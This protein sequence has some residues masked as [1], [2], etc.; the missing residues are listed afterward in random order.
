MPAIGAARSFA[1]MGSLEKSRNADPSML[2]KL[3][4][5]GAAFTDEQWS[6]IAAEEPWS[7][8]PEPR[9][10]LDLHDL[11]LFVKAF[12]HDERDRA[13]AV[14]GLERIAERA[15]ALAARRAGYMRVL[16]DS[17]IAGLPLQARFSIDLCRWMCE[18]E[19]GAAAIDSLEGEEDRLRE[20]L[21]ASALPAERDAMDDTRF[22]A[23]SR[24]NDACGG[25]DALRWLIRAIDGLAPDPLARHALWESCGINV[26]LCPGRSPMARTWCEGVAG[27]VHAWRHGTKASVDARAIISTPLTDNGSVEG[28][29]R[30]SALA[31]ARGVL[32]GY[33]RETDPLTFCQPSA[34]RYHDM[35]Q[36][37]GIALFTMPPHRRAVFDPYVGYMAFSNAVPVAYGGAWLFPGKS[38]VGINVFPAFRGGPSQ[39]LFAQILRCYAQRYGVGCFEAENYQLGHGNSDGIRSGAYWF[40]HR[41][42]FRTPDPK[43]AAVAEAEARSMRANP[44]HR[45]KPALLRKLA[46]V[47][48]HLD[49]SGE[50]APVFEPLDLSERVLHHLATVSRGDRSSAIPRIVRR[51]ARVLGVEE[52]LRSWPAEDRL[53]FGML[54]PAVHPILDLKEWSASEKRGLVAVMRA[55]GA[56]TEDKYLLLLR[57]HARLLASWHRLASGT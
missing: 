5:S 28:A 29:Q 24:L 9:T 43:L 23:L 46:A 42:G 47:P 57:R 22:D 10:I 33:Q 8:D 45:T 37:I 18:V 44:A 32:V 35:G 38:K 54:A 14:A 17:G 41:L 51:V 21:L 2:R 49:L 4:A 55:K 7:V 6:G 1:L 26:T 52:A 53:G 20:L 50:N 36:G 34:V 48:M 19:P 3:Y 13:R 31:A 25:E 56:I 40:Y 39:L 11:L 16:R 12:P 30:R 27:P 15:A